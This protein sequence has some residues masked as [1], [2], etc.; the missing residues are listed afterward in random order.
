VATCPCCGGGVVSR[1]AAVVTGSGI[2]AVA[3]CG[4]PPAVGYGVAEDVALATRGS[5]GV[6]NRRPDP[7]VPRADQD[8]VAWR[9]G[10]GNFACSGIGAESGSIA[11]YGT[12]CPG[13]G[14]CG[15][16]CCTCGAAPAAAAAAAAAV[17]AATAVVR[18]RLGTGR[19]RPPPMTRL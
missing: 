14:S 7:H 6:A 12:A 5:T 17:P 2:P 3:R 4:I 13:G 18:A 10:R 1:A 16:S 19:S 15:G 9:C 8:V 11:C